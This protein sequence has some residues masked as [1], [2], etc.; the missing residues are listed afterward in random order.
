MANIR[1]VAKK[2][3]VSVATVSRFINKNGYVKESTSKKI[4]KVIEQLNY[5]P[6]A[7]AIGL[8]NKK[9]KTLGLIL[10]DIT[11]PFFSTLAKAVGEAVEK[12]GYTMLLCNSNG[13]LESEIKHIEMMESKYVAG[14]IL[15]SN[16]FDDEHY[17]N[18][19]TPIVLV[20]RNTRGDFS[21]VTANNYEGGKLAAHH[22]L[23]IG[24]K[25]IV[26]LAGP[27]NIFTA[28]QRLKGYKDVVQN[29]DWFSEQLIIHTPYSTEEAIQ[30]THKL[31][32]TD[33]DI[34][35]IFAGNDLIAIGCLKAIHT[36]GLSCPHD[37]A[38]IGFDGISVTQLVIPEL[39]TIAQP[40]YEMGC[41]AV[42]IIF[43]QISGALNETIFKELDVELIQ[44][45]ST[46]RSKEHTM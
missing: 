45:K 24:C 36:L 10:P 5:K 12:K 17:K 16:T 42:D 6:N 44:R 35:G 31:L 41:A 4:E 1:D 22:L 37:I 3:G 27:E 33:K 38:V 34:D 29:F 11:N 18:F 20:D 23:D 8:S 25:K 2:A 28:K 15:I 43:K 26:H 40:I 46:K 30:V 32:N 13:E 14:I 39:S 19:N 9:I 21:T 7:I